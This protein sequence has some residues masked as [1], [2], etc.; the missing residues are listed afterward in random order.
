MKIFYDCEFVERGRD[1]PMQLVSIGMICEDGR[2]LYRINP[3]SLSN[4]AIH[5]WL[6]VNVAPYLPMTSPSAG[7]IAWDEKHEEYQYVSMSFTQLIDDV[8]TFIQATPDAELWA[9]YGAYDHVLLCQLF[10]S[11][12]ELPAGVPMITM[13]VQQHWLYFG[14]GKPLP[15]EPWHAH[16]AMHDARWARDAFE[17]ISTTR[18]ERLALTVLGA[19]DIVDAAII[20]EPAEDDRRNPTKGER[21]P[22]DD[23]RDWINMRS[24]Y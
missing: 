2:E 13:D 7:I 11:M 8:L 24:A 10:G 16:H 20:E 22:R 5:P 4:V 14:D 17:S 19:T 23:E 1:V 6:S 12:S 18:T 9:Y 3:E 21:P 15:P